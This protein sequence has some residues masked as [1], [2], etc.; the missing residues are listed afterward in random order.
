MND[1]S[2]ETMAPP[3]R[4]SP[5]CVVPEAD[6]CRNRLENLIP[7][8]QNQ[9]LSVNRTGES[10]VLKAFPGEPDAIK[11]D[12]CCSKEQVSIAPKVPPV[13]LCLLMQ[14]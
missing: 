3:E 10:R 1:F 9:N 2:I 8:P 12:N 7:C 11:F 4:E 6:P 13:T 5:E 14:S